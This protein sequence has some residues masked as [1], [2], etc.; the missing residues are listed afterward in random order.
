MCKYEIDNTSLSRESALR[1]TV[2]TIVFGHDPRSHTEKDGIYKIEK[3][4]KKTCKTI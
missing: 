3:S 4:L 2:K 1:K